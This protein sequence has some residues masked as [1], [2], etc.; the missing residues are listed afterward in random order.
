M[1]KPVM[2]P[3]CGKELF[4][5][6]AVSDSPLVLGKNKAGP[7]LRTDQHGTFMKCPHC[8]KRVIFVSAPST[9]GVGFKLG[10][11]QPCADCE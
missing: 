10:E 6:G 7:D 1:S 11:V 9:V 5:L 4:R 3:C 8:S 2:C